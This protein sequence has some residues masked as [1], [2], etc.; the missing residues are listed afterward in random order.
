MA[1]AEMPSVPANYFQEQAGV[2]ALSAVALSLRCVWRPTPNA[3]VGIDGQLE[4]FGQEGLSTGHVVAVQIKSGSSY[5]ERGTEAEIYYYPQEKHRQYWAQFPIPVILA[6]HDP[7]TNLIHWTDARRYLRA[8]FTRKNKEIRVPR[9]QVLNS[10]SKTAL[11]ETCG[12]FDSPL[13]SVSEVAQRLASSRTRN[14]TFDISFLELFTLGKIDIGRKVFFN[15]DLC[16]Q[17]ACAKPPVV[18]GETEDEA[19]VAEPSPCSEDYDFINEYVRF[20]VSQSLI[21]YDF[22]DFLIDWDER[23]VAPVFACPLTHRGREVQD[24]LNSLVR[25]DNHFHENLIRIEFLWHLPALVAEARYVSGVLLGR[26]KNGGTP[27]TDPPSSPA[28]SE[29]DN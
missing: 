29:G 4:L 13:L 2:L 21:Y 8:D 3:D 17:I 19:L 22:Y 9:S 18:I 1:D 15:M 14:H 12:A 7:A 25:G 11:F 24:Y 10:D 16:H 26:Q 5:L 23:Q 27:T 20:L 28:P 6:I